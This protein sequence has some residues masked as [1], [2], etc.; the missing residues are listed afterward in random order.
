MKVLMKT[1][2]KCPFC[3]DSL[4]NEYILIQQK[5]EYLN[6]V[7][8]K[9]LSHSIT[10]RPCRRNE[11]Y[12]DWICIPLNPSTN[13]IWYMGIGSICIN[14]GVTKDI[15]LPFFIPNLTNFRKLIDKVKTYLV[16]S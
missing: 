15:D 1:P 14:N 11:D 3:G 2:T 7:C 4:R 6:L 9:R 12:V 10:I 13:V 16:F 8:D 5:V